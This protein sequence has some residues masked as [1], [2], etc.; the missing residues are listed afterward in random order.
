MDPIFINWTSQ[1]VTESTPEF[2][3]L[4]VESWWIKSGFIRTFYQRDMITELSCQRV[5]SC[6]VSML[7][8]VAVKPFGISVMDTPC[9]IQPPN[10]HHCSAYWTTNHLTFSSTPH[11]LMHQLLTSSFKMWGS[12]GRGTSTVKSSSSKLKQTN[13]IPAGQQF[14]A[15]VQA[16]QSCIL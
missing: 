5:N 15:P 2:Q 12:M 13:I 4:P 11:P 1:F 14:C 16:E 3:T 10:S 8:W 9:T 7:C 6:T